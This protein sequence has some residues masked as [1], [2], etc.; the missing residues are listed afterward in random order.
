MP[1]KVKAAGVVSIALNA[2]SLVVMSLAL[3][4]VGGAGLLDAGDEPDEAEAACEGG[5]KANIGF[6]GAGCS[7]TAGADDF[8]LPLPK[9]EG[10]GVGG[11][12]LLKLKAVGLD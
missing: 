2:G 3:S 7:M 5:L 11:A 12:P 1:D 8:E 4:A 6:A 9:N 10:A